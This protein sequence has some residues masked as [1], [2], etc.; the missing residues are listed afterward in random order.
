MPEKYEIKTD[1]Q[2]IVCAWKVLKGCDYDNR[3]WDIVHFARCSRSAKNLLIIF[4]KDYK[5]AIDCM[6][7]VYNE[8]T[9]KNLSCSIETVVKWSSEWRVKDDK[10]RNGFGVE[11][12][13]GQ[14][15]LRF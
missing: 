11:R 13:R 15:V 2:R 9:G 7:D 8:L 14:D 12:K 4:D 5:R 10:R 6:E 3:S 1:I